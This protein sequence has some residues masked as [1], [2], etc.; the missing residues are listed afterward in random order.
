M[1]Q[2]FENDRHDKQHF[3]IKYTLSIILGSNWENFKH[4]EL[5]SNLSPIYPYSFKKVCI[6]FSSFNALSMYNRKF[7]KNCT[8]T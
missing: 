6:I 8:Y 2:S 1:K 5:K 7:T 3:E 4:I